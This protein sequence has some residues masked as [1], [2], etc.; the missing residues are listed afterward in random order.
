MTGP[1][2]RGASAVPDV[3]ARLEGLEDLPVDLQ[4]RTLA[5]IEADLR[6]ALDATRG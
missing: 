3:D 6:T 4:I 5:G 1:D 2:P